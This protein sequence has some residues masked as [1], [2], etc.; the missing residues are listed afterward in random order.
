MLIHTNKSAYG[1]TSKIINNIV[2]NSPFS[3]TVGAAFLDLTSWWLVKYK[4]SQQALPHEI[5]FPLEA[6]EG[7]DLE[8]A[9]R[10]LLFLWSPES[11]LCTSPGAAATFHSVSSLLAYFSRLHHW[12]QNPLKS[13]LMPGSSYSS[14]SE[15]ESRSVVSNSLWPHG[16]NLPG[17]SM[18]GILQAG[19]PEWVV[20]PFSR[21]SSQPRGR[22]QVSHIV[23][24]FFTVWANR[25]AHSSVKF[26]LKLL[27]SYLI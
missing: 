11:L 18:H 6:T 25:E 27:L 22:T 19:I 2:Q 17:S 26:C 8:Q 9:K 4:E 7:Q 23:G 20:I 21:G 14:V 16:F 1:I 5:H 15:S 13:G 10:S 12:N 3:W 24:R